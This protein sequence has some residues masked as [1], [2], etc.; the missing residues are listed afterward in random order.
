MTV[1]TINCS[2]NGC[3]HSSSCS[4]SISSWFIAVFFILDRVLLESSKDDAQAKKVY[5][6]SLKQFNSLIHKQEQLLRGA[7]YS[8]MWF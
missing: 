4:C 3:S 7:L 8:M 1:E 6:K 2:S 5:Q